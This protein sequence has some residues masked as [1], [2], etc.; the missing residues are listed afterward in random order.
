MVG[1]RP[2]QDI[3]DFIFPES[4]IYEAADRICEEIARKQAICSDETIL[5]G[6]VCA[7]HDH[8]AGH[9]ATDKTRTG[10]VNKVDF[11]MK[12]G[13]ALSSQDDAFVDKMDMANSK[14]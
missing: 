3:P 11:S 9:V 10:L 13:V 12:G 8:N 14:P 4:S 7:S 6:V 2:T 5:K 1:A